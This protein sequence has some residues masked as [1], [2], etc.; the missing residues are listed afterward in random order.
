MLGNNIDRFP[1]ILL[2][3]ALKARN[4][5]VRIFLCINT[6]YNQSIAENEDIFRYV[7]ALRG[8]CRIERI[9]K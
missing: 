5:A 3:C 6:K 8:K 2:K 4:T 9:Y 1:Q 7:N